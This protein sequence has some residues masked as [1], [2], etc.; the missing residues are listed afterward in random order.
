MATNQ[1]QRPRYYEDQYI[2]A[3]D[4]SQA[5]EY[6]RV[7][8]ARHALGGHTWGITLGFELLERERSGGVIDVYVT[9]GYAWDG[10][11][12]SIVMLEPTP[13]GVQH[14]Q[15]YP[16]LVGVDDQNPE[17]RLFTVWIAYDEQ[18]G[19]G[20][21]PGFEVC[22]VNDQ[23][24]RVE[25]KFRLEVTEYRPPSPPPV[26]GDHDTII[27]AGESVAA[28]DALNIP[29]ISPP[30]SQIN[31]ESIPF[32]VFPTP[33]ERKRW[34]IPI[35]VVRWQPPHANLAGR[36]I[37]RI[38]ADLAEHQRARRYIGV[39]AESVEAT[40]AH[41]RI[42]N[43]N[44]DNSQ[45]WT[46]DLAWIEGK[47]RVDGDA[48]L[49]N[50]ALLL[51]NQNNDEKDFPV[52][53]RRTAV[54]TSKVLQVL[55]G[56]EAKG[57]NRFSI[58][59]EVGGNAQEKLVVLDDGKVGIGTVAPPAKLTVFAENDGGVDA[60]QIHGAES[61]ASKYGVLNVH[62]AEEYVRL[63]YLNG[64]QKKNIFLDGKVGVG[65][66]KPVGRLTLE[67]VVQPQQGTLSFFT[68][69][70]DM[71]YDGGSDKLFIFKNT[72][73]DGKTAFL[74]GNVGIGAANPLGKLTVEAPEHI[75]VILDRTD[76]QDHMTLTVGSDGS[77]IHFSNG[78]RFFISADAYPD[79]NTKGFGNELFTLLAS[80]NVGIGTP[81]PSELLSLESPRPYLEFRR[82]GGGS[83]YLGMSDGSPG[84]DFLFGFPR[85]SGHPES[86]LHRFW[87][88]QRGSGGEHT[89]IVLDDETGVHVF[90]PG[91]GGWIFAVSDEDS[92][93]RTSSTL[94]T[95]FIV[96][97][98]GKV[99]I[100]VDAPS[101]LLHVNGSAAKP[102]GGSWTSSSDQRLKKNI[103]PLKGAL[104]KL[105]S[106]RGV[107]FE[108]KE[109][110]KQGN[111]TGKQI[112]LIAQ[113]VEKVFP[114]WVGVS[115]EGYKD[116]TVRG[117]EALTVE[118]LKDL[119]NEIDSLKAAVKQ[120][121][122]K[123]QVSKAES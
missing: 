81:T 63:G 97:G 33:G 55:I 61:S 38:G 95:K 107:V 93:T 41:V 29:K 1:T 6:G 21:R 86:N 98:D 119:K 46:D 37:K 112:G 74:G 66:P 102:G 117:F 60:L 22:D 23:N 15:S 48:R 9:P 32:Q 27:V 94:S 115:A 45:L 82:E 62:D 19:V 50:G 36:F 113:E 31:D 12:R 20:P 17:G 56:N 79:R 108:W 49:L 84:L 123:S 40:A 34:P 7:Q 77:G 51:R 83:A 87:M 100:G 39:A 11:G 105:I 122:Q 70:A 35:G 47:L 118:A 76:S 110:E 103:E 96:R 59:P 52:T 109:P 44:K 14:F 42:K 78:N 10:F 99:G 54:A 80:G 5:V 24:S 111:L 2:G 25:E 65:M 30:P 64:A 69:D 104:D 116:L 114:E 72:S 3:D 57:N 26:R 101:Y 43:R 13:L 53:I 75:N 91:D 106:L 120:H 85:A 92:Y 67:G 4:L 16:F 8:V 28:K 89:G 68:N 73:A 71:A 88:V 58:G 121:K 18:G 90:G